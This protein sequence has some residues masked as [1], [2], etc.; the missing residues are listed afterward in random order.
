MLLGF[1]L[2][3]ALPVFAAAAS[4]SRPRS[5]LANAPELEKRVTYSETKISL[6]ELVAKVSSDTGVPLTAARDVADEPVAVVVTDFP[7]RELLEQLADL[8][9]YRWSRRPTTDD[10][11]LTTEESKEEPSGVVGGRS[12]VVRGTRYEIYQ[13][14]A[15]RQREAALRRALRDGVEERFQESLAIYQDLSGKSQEEMERL[16]HEGTRWRER[17]QTLTPEERHAR[18]SSPEGRRQSLS[19]VLAR[20]LWSPIKRSLAGLTSRLTPEQWAALRAGRQIVFSSDPKPG[21][22]AL[23]PD[24]L[25]VFRTSRLIVPQPG[26]LLPPPSESEEEERQRREKQERWDQAEQFDVIFRLLAFEA[27]WWDPGW[28]QFAA[29]TQPFRGGKRLGPEAEGANPNLYISISPDM[30]FSHAEKDPERHALLE[31][32]PVLSVKKPFQPDTGPYVD[33]LFPG[34]SRRFRLLPEYLPELAR[35]YGVHFIADSYWSAPSVSSL[36]PSAAP[37]PLFEL[38]E[39]LTGLRYGGDRGTPYVWD[40]RGS[41]IRIRART[42]CEDR[43]RE[44]PLRHVRRW[45]ALLDRRGALPLEELLFAASTLTDVQGDA[46]GR[47]FETGVFPSQMSDLRSLSGSLSLLRLYGRLSAAQRQA[48]LTGEVLATAQLSPALR[49]LLLS[50][51]RRTH[52][53][54]IPIPN[55]DEWSGG[56]LLLSR[57]PDV[58]LRERRGRSVTFRLDSAPAPRVAMP[59]DAVTRFPVARLRL[60]FHAGVQAPTAVTLIVAAAT[61]PQE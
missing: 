36:A 14:L 51:L 9:D 55:L 33:A 47:L 17:L 30:S 32:D 50:Q 6:G 27:A 28:I 25:R 49:P 19:H 42:W 18:Q 22:L 13:D 31:Q 60:E 1:I 3:C 2:G 4:E 37:R 44:I 29:F 38:L 41:L 8:L 15:S 54:R 34:A 5:V 57:T 39:S 40:R 23:P 35:A 61:A 7:A 21:K 24:V 53:G 12:S 16:W 48:L 11:P 20:S 43:H 52:R 46:L 10:R 56:H 59:P 26:Q 45:A 58:R